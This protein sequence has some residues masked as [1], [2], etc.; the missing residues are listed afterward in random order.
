LL[1]CQKSTCFSW[2]EYETFFR[3]TDDNFLFQFF[4]YY[5]II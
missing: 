5:F 3:Q 1:Q 2:Y 4:S